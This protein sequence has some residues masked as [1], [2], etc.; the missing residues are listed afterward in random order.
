LVG[1]P[2]IFILS[3]GA[4]LPLHDHPGMSVVSRVLYGSLHVRA[5]DLLDARGQPVAHTATTGVA[6]DSTRQ[7]RLCTDAVLAAP[8]TTDLAPDHGNLH[9]FVAGGER[10]CA[11][12]DILTP[13]YDERAGRDCTY[14]RVAR[15]PQAGAGGNGDADDEGAV[16]LGQVVTL[17]A[18]DPVF[19]VRSEPYHGPRLQRFV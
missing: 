3:P 6:A 11:I 4:S 16:K 2:S 15:E 1:V 14:Y 7:A 13:P 8:H 12:F 9:E 18:F 10:G 5:F 17:E 19:E